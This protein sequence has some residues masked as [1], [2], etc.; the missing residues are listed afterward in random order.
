MTAVVRN[1]RL[2]TADGVREGDISFRNGVIEG[3]G[4]GLGGE[5]IADLNGAWVLPGAVD[6]HVHI[7]LGGHSITEPLLHDL[8]QAR[9]RLCGAALPPSACTRSEPR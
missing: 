5:T 7:S 2:V 9:G 3:I 1:G 6:P 8:H 4:T